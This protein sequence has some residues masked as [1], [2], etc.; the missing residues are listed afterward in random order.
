MEATEKMKVTEGLLDYCE[1]I[2]EGRFNSVLLVGR[3]NDVSNTDEHNCLTN[4]N[5]YRDTTNVREF[6]SLL[7]ELVKH[8]HTHNTKKHLELVSREFTQDRTLLSNYDF[9]IYW[10]FK[11]SRGTCASVGEYNNALEKY[12]NAARE[13][14]NIV[15]GEIE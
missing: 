6:V 7:R 4:V 10:A 14:K 15:W 3:R 8:F 1:H 9:L 12:L 11:M 13:G 5:S 2:I